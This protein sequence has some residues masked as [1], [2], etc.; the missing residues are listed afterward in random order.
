MSKSI[1]GQTVA[2]VGCPAAYQDPEGPGGIPVI[3]D[4]LFVVEE[5]SPT[6]RAAF[7][8]EPQYGVSEN[9][10]GPMYYVNAEEFTKQVW[11]KSYGRELEQ[12][13]EMTLHA[14]ENES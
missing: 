14:E 13:R 5:Y 2:F 1:I 3:L 8:D 6:D 12:E 9:A 11:P 4:G 7:I 10:A